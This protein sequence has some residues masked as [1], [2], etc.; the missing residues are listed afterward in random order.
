MTHQITLQNKRILLG[1]TGGVA[2]YKAAELARLLCG[3]GAQVRVVMS[4]G[5]TA[6]IAP[7][8]FQALTRQPVATELLD[9]GQEAVMNH[10]ELARWAEAV[11]IA[12]ATAHC[13]AKLR[14]GL[15]DDLLSTLCL[16]TVAPLL[17]APAMN[18]AMW[19]NPAT[20]ENARVLQARGVRL[21]G[22]EAG[23]LACGEVG[24]GRMAAPEAVVEA[25]AGLWQP[26]CLAG[27]SVLVSAGPTREAIDPVRFLSNRS[28]GKMGYAVA[29]AA[30][31]AGARVCLVSGPTALPPPAVDEYVVVE[32][33]AEMMQAVMARAAAHAIYIGAAAVADYAPQ[34]A[35]P[36]KIKKTAATLSLELHKTQDIL[37]AVAALPDKPFTVGFAAETHDL[38]NYARAKLSAKNLDMVAANWVGQNLGFDRDENALEVYWPGGHRQLPTA[39]KPALAADLLRLIAERFAV[40]TMKN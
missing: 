25:L 9:S 32:S 38:E 6:F 21:I 2:A 11:L 18:S 10:I 17:L 37:A 1:V 36:G 3:A 4:G 34:Q 7:L 28:S 35:G 29:E 16:A 22:P 15:A 19:A 23:D 24:L 27:L 12:P 5:A 8:T 30:R 31:A 33:A 26:G 40:Q 13:L 39:P 14:L 20:Q